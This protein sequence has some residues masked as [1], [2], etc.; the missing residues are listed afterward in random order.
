MHYLGLLTLAV[1]TGLLHLQASTDR[2]DL[3]VYQ[4]VL[5]SRIRPEVNRHSAALGAPTPAPV[6]AYDR[7]LALCGTH[8]D[9]TKMNCISD[10]RVV[11]RFGRVFQ[12]AVSADSRQEIT[13]VFR[14]RNAAS[15][16][17]PPEKLEGVIT[18]PPEDAYE[19]VKRESRRTR[20][21]S[22]FSLPAYSSDGYAV[23]YGSYVCGGLCGYGWLFLLQ[24]QGG[25]WRVVATEM[26]WIS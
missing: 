8:V 24:Q 19:A 13:R 20:G 3:A 12:T 1:M 9:H 16:P 22:S 25:V 7:T 26:L 11:Q 10:E 2:H 23:V 21:I 17:F 5:A 14:Q 6:L 4:A 15:S 18:V